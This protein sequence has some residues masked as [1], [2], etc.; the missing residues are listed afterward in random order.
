MFLDS[1]LTR[2]VEQSRRSFLFV[3]LAESGRETGNRF[4]PGN[5]STL[6]SV[7]LSETILPC[8]FPFARRTEIFLSPKNYSLFPRVTFIIIFNK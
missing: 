1:N 2:S 7:I 4:K 8:V 5:F 6:P 3:P